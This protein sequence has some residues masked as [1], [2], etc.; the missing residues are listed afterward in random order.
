MKR[1]FRLLLVS[2]FIMLNF[3]CAHTVPLTNTYLD[4]Y[5]QIPRTDKS[6]LIVINKET[7]GK[8][9]EQ[10]RL[11]STWVFN[12]GE[13]IKTTLTDAMQHVFSKVEVAS[14][15]ENKDKFDYV[16]KA[17]LDN[18]K[19]A[20]AKTIH[21]K[22]IM[23]IQINY[24][25]NSA[26]GNIFSLQDITYA[27]KKLSSGQASEAFLSAALLGVAG[28][29]HASSIYD[30]NV[31]MSWDIALCNSIE[32]LT[33]E[34]KMYF[35]VGADAYDKYNKTR[36]SDVDKT[37]ISLGGSD[38]LYKKKAAEKI[39]DKYLH[40]PE[41]LA[42]VNKQL[43]TDYNISI[44]NNLHVEAVRAMCKVLGADKNLTYQSTLA[45]ISTSATNRLVRSFA[46]ENMH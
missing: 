3:A 7:S 1:F 32:G 20:L 29:A 27:E 15:D 24:S 14:S 5:E 22:N 16:L 36:P 39:Y 9:I 33:K 12:A 26:G 31:G 46:H 45:T 6:L 37:I 19:I 30:S 43:L 4:T 23:A 11:T 41:A 8:V 34:I 25:F 44:T 2:I 28:A 21:S 18:Y 17:E 13:S 10:G 42:A 40:V 35:E 38:E